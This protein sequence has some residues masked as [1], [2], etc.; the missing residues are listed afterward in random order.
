MV[1]YPCFLVLAGDSRVFR[2][3]VMLSGLKS[4]RGP[5]RLYDEV[6]RSQKA[7]VTHTFLCIGDAGTL[8]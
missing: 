2:K 4:Y 3:N 5:V 7:V 1:L 8:T 6:D